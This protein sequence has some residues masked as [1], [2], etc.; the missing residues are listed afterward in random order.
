[1]QTCGGVKKNWVVFK[2]WVLFLYIIPF[3][4]ILFTH[5]VADISSVMMSATE[6]VKTEFLTNPVVRKGLLYPLSIIQLSVA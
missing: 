3:D 4:N 5:S 2:S 6:V 1:M